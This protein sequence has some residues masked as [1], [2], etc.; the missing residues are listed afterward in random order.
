MI[1]LRDKGCGAYLLAFY[2][3][4]EI[5]LDAQD[6]IETITISFI[7]G[8]NTKYIDALSNS[9]RLSLLPL[10]GLPFTRIQP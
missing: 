10:P 2:L 1:A 7:Y 9:N 8:P 5:L 3:A 4:R 6:M